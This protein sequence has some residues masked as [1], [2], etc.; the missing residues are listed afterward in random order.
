MR[1]TL[2]LLA[3]LLALAACSK[4]D[5]PKVSAFAAPPAPVTE[6]KAAAK[7][8]DPDFSP[9]SSVLFRECR[10]AYSV[11][12]CTCTVKMVKEEVDDDTY[13]TMKSMG[14]TG[15]LAIKG[16]ASDKLHA[17]LGKAY[18]ACAKAEDDAVGVPPGAGPKPQETFQPTPKAAPK[19]KTK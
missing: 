15:V 9:G 2:S 10:Q 8:V 19:A 5:S 17:V 7:A 13:K 14:M 3:S 4:D 18:D 12:S 16:A 1:T 11:A 6:P